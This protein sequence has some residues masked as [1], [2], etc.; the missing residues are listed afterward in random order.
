MAITNDTPQKARIRASTNLAEVKGAID[1]PSLFPGDQIT[2]SATGVAEQITATPTTCKSIW[3]GSGNTSNAAKIEIGDVNGQN[4]PVNAA[5]D[6]GFSLPITDASFVYI[7]GTAGDK[8][9]YRIM[10]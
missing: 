6:T 3:F 8:L 10:K 2:L 7:K 1:S 9:N 5:N 4:I